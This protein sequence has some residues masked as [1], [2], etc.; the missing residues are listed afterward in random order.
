[1][2][3]VQSP[4]AGL[5]VPNATVSPE[6]GTDVEVKVDVEEEVDVDGVVVFEQLARTVARASSSAKHRILVKLLAVEPLTKSTLARSR[7]PEQGVWSQDPTASD[8]EP[9]GTRGAALPRV[10]AG[11]AVRLR[12]GDLDW[13]PSG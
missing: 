3:V 2:F 8:A 11:R 7:G 10:W 1:M 12:P 5:F 13:S 4:S 9:T 6:A